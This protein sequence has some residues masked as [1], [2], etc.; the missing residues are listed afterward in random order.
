MSDS[1]YDPREPDPPDGDSLPDHHGVEAALPALESYFAPLLLSRVRR[2]PA[3]PELARRREPEDVLEIVWLKLRRQLERLIGT[4][5][6][7]VLCT[8]LRVLCDRTLSELLEQER[9][10]RGEG[11]SPG[12]PLRTGPA[13]GWTEAEVEG[14]QSEVDSDE[15]LLTLAR[16]VLSEGEL[17][18]WQHVDRGGYT[19]EEV[20][21]LVLDC[22]AA[23]VDELLEQARAKLV[24]LQ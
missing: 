8:S 11:R 7:E 24:P 4:P 14:D 19:A 2:S 10:R 13:D 23:D 12:A 20:G 1:P 22:S 16:L 18:A 3:W 15:E 21:D 9:A 6:R 5:G 17:L